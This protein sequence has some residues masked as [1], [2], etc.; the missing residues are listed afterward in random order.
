MNSTNE[1]SN[2]DNIESQEES[3]AVDTL[4]GRLF[5]AREAQGLSAR[6]L[7]GKVGV[8]SRTLRAWESDRSEPR[9]N[10][11]VTLA[12]VLNASPNWLL[13]GE[14]EIPQI[15]ANHPEVDRIQHS[16]LQL[17]GQ[18]EEIVDEIERLN[19][20]VGTLTKSNDDS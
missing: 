15:N 11:L 3:L 20:S 12:G 6:Q 7:A 9:S 5:F 4:G 13:T 19:N 14:G 8:E 17:K 2:N 16:L 18:L 10:K 1:S